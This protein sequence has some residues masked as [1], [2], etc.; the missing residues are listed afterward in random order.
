MEEKLLNEYYYNPAHPSGFSNVRKLSNTLK[1]YNIEK[2][3]IQNWLE[4]QDT[5][6]LHKP[7]RR[8]FQR[9][10]YHVTN[11]NDLFQIDLIDLLNIKQY[12]QDYCYLLSVI[13][14]FSKYAWVK[15]LKNKTGKEVALALEDIFSK[16]KRIPLNISSDRGKEFLATA[17][18]NLFKKYSINFYIARNPD[19]KAS[20]VERFNKT[21]KSR[22]FKFF[23]YNYTW[24]SW[25][26][27]FQL[28]FAQ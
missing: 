7:V 9:N 18:Q 21:L 20:V 11:I 5:Y 19:V 22:M 4:S 15:P 24:S 10:R 2:Y 17:V 1:K 12:N 27:Q 26:Y 16:D 6:T 23:T 14:V 3:K 13:D 8:N 25:N 28:R